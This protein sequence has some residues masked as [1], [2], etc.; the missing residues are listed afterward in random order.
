MGGNM[1]LPINDL[2]KSLIENNLQNAG[3]KLLYDDLQS[4]ADKF[5]KRFDIDQIP[6]EKRIGAQ[7]SVVFSTPSYACSFTLERLPAGWALL[8]WGVSDRELPQQ[9]GLIQ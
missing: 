2:Y 4:K 6:E 1:R 9:E 8:S 7:C 3:G 5:E